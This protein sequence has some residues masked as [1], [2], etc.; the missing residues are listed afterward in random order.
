M[1]LNVEDVNTDK[2]IHT[3]IPGDLSQKIKYEYVELQE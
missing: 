2:I 3:E 1:N